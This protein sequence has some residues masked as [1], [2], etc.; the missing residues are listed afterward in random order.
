[1]IL[2]HSSIVK[3]SPEFN[4]VSYLSPKLACLLAICSQARFSLQP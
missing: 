1:M 2:I 3:L 4:F